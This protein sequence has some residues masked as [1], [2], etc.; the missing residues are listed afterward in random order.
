MKIISYHLRAVMKILHHFVVYIQ[1]KRHI[2]VIALPY[3]WLSL[4]FL[5]PFLLIVKI[6][7]SKSVMGIPP[8]TPIF[9]WVDDS[10]IQMQIYL[11]NY[12]AI[13][14]DDLYILTFL[15]SIKVAGISVTISLILGFMM[16]YGISR[17][18]PR[19]RALCLIL[20]VLP[21]WT[22]FLIRV[23]AWMS[24]LS[25]KGAINHF[26]MMMGL[27]KEPL[28]LLNN[29]YAV[30]VG[31]VYC[32]LP[33]MVLPIYTSLAKIDQTLIEASFDLGATP[34]HTFWHITVPLAMP[35]IIAGFILVFVPAVGEFVIPELLGGSD[36]LMIGRML[37]IEFFNNRDWPQAC[38]L[39]VSMIMLVVTP[40]MIFQSKQKNNNHHKKLSASK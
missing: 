9:T 27:I 23:Y 16:A 12:I 21:F 19:L 32:Y 8:F 20:V 18:T 10:L 14:K 1:N 13:I 24:L 26:L 5:I 7:L 6:S 40:L 38:A 35:G 15:S 17:A 2:F 37:W 25:A 22:S 36:T 29:P 4:F 31:I 34:W 39:A 3:V 28:M 30:C 33:F 11:H